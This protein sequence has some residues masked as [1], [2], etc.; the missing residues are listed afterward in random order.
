MFINS[1]NSINSLNYN[2]Q[3][4]F[5]GGPNPEVARNQMRIFLTQD[6]WAPKLTVR[7]P[8]SQLEKETLLE[9]L[10]QRLQLDRLARLTND[11]FQ[12]IANLSIYNDLI[13]Q[14][15]NSEEATALGK[16]IEK[17]G[18]LTSYFKTINEQIELEK[19]KHRPAVEFFENLENLEKEYYAQKLVKD[20]KMIKFFD[21]VRKYNINAGGKYSTKELIEIIE[22]GKLPEESTKTELVETSTKKILSA[23]DLL[24]MVEKDYENYLRE[25]V[26]VYGNNINHYED[27]MKAQ[28][29]IAEKYKESIQRYPNI[30]KQ[31][32]RV[33]E[34]VQNKFV[35]KINRIVKSG[36]DDNPIGEHWYYMGE[37]E[38]EIRGLLKEIKTLEARLAKEPANK[39]L[40]EDI[41]MKRSQIDILKAQWIDKM[42]ISLEQI[43]SNKPVMVAA[44]CLNEYL[45]LTEKSKLIL[46]L[47]E[48]N[49][50]YQENG[51]I[52]EEIWTKILEN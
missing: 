27:A 5:K 6:I 34:S 15:P 38:K 48:I 3:T 4:Q 41:E 8:Q 39:N 20:G 45:Y 9:V 1:I 18:N 42:I 36:A 30:Q 33:Y 51:T 49:R 11:R 12:T 47:K 29:M 23:K 2:K 10:K 50:I 43:E 7:M 32:N 17:K 37:Y 22:S 31:L 35:H 52:P 13:E 24:I 19:K 40:C 28:K 44:G 14:N 21:Q 16:E 26:N 46:E 25:N